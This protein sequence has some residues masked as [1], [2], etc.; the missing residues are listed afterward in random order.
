MY[1]EDRLNY[2]QIIRTLFLIEILIFKILFLLLHHQN[3]KM[4][5][6]IVHT[7]HHHHHHAGKGTVCNFL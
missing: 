6:Q 4:N 1:E 7:V 2:D 3:K 5:L